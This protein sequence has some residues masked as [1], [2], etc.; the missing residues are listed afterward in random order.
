MFFSAEICILRSNFVAQSTKINRFYFQRY[1]NI[2]HLQRD[3]ATTFMLDEG[4]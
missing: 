4:V 3:H 2:A 1:E